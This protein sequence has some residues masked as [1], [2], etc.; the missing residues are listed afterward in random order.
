MALAIKTREI[1]YQAK[2]GTTLIGYFAAPES[3]QPVAG[4]IVGPEWWGRN[5]YSEQRAREL[6]QH[7][8]AALAIDMYGDKKTTAVAT[9]AHEWMMQT[10]QHEQTLLSVQPRLWLL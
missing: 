5:E 9:Q 1:Q 2:D 3:A 4:V 6:A 7:G 8:F 10:F